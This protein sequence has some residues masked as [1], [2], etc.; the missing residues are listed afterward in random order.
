VTRVRRSLAA[1]VAAGLAG[2]LL[3][4]AP[5]WA[6]ASPAV[7][8]L[9][10]VTA[11]FQHIQNAKAA[12][13]GK[14]KD[15][16]GIACIEDADPAMGGMGIH[17]VNGDLVGDSEVLA[18]HPEALVYQPTE[19]GLKLVAVEYIV[20]RKAWRAEHPTGRPELYGEKLLAVGKDNRYGIPPFFE[21]HVWAWKHNPA[22]MFMDM[23]PRVQCP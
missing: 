20:L 8:H 17:F 4:T 13:Y 10:D 23:N 7:E 18:D 19:D 2:A 11:Q 1:V 6:G 14:L 9:R 5:A 21:I 16:A 3:S 22:G 15:A 12:G